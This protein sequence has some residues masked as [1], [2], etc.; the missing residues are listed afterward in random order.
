MRFTDLVKRI[1]IFQ[2][3]RVIRVFTAYNFIVKLRL[4]SLINLI[5]MIIGLRFVQLSNNKNSPIPLTPWSKIDLK[6]IDPVDSKTGNSCDILAIFLRKLPN[7]FEIRVDFLFENDVNNCE[8]KIIF[9]KPG[10][11]NIILSTNKNENDNKNPLF[12]S[13]ILNNFQRFILVS[14]PDEF[15]KYEVNFEARDNNNNLC[16]STN[17]TSLFEQSPSPIYIRLFAYDTHPGYLPSQIL[18]N[19]DGAHTGPNGQRHG[20][21]HFLSAAKITSTPVTLLDLN[22]PSGLAAIEF[23]GISEELLNLQK[24]SMLFLPIAV[25]LSGSLGQVAQELGLQSAISHKYLNQNLTCFNNKTGYFL[26]VYDSEFSFNIFQNL[27]N[28]I[29]LTN[30]SVH[31]DPFTKN[32]ISEGILIRIIENYYSENKPYNISFSISNS[33]IA[34]QAFA[35]NIFSFF[36]N[37]PWM[38]I[39]T[40]F[41]NTLNKPDSLDASIT[42]V[43]SIPNYSKEIEA[44]ILQSKG[45]FQFHMVNY[46]N[47]IYGR[48]QSPEYQK[49]INQYQANIY[50][51]VNANTWAEKEGKE[52]RCDLDIDL[53]G[54]LECILSNKDYYAIVEMDGGR[55]AFLAA[56][57]NNAVYQIIAPASTIMFGLSTTS[58][59]NVGSEV[60]SD[61]EELPGAFFDLK[62]KWD[63][64]K[65]VEILD[66]S[67]TLQGIDQTNTKNFSLGQDGLKLV[68]SDTQ[69]SQLFIPV[70]FGP[71]CMNHTD[72][73]KNYR[74]SSNIDQSKIYIK[75]S[76]ET[77]TLTSR[78]S[79]ILIESTFLESINV[80]NIPENPDYSYTNGHYQKL[81]LSL[82]EINHNQKNLVSITIG[83]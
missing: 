28:T 54:S 48:V 21:K 23:L 50:Y 81:G 44:A 33:N 76:S 20:L 72:W 29:Y 68:Q 49:L 59:W 4:L 75:C 47:D 64:Y 13:I 38:E 58:E 74:I 30:E 31:S 56:R 79:Q 69:N 78:F 1:F 70:I 22:S 46:L 61:S 55:L 40:P 6:L 63:I 16:D 9:K 66:N 37:H 24:S 35:Y 26:N 17:F 3:I 42:F 39:I 41:E 34:D 19:W 18:R 11:G 43:T 51:Y 8:L 60:W 71:D 80:M 73:Q 5:I 52:T 14:L 83:K 36:Q 65:P 62:E 25:N 82:F 45:P 67:I 53:D 10:Y 32:G 57:S 27:T 7:K 2:L 15:S 12:H 77:A